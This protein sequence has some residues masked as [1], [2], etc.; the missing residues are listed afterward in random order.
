M[1]DRNGAG[2]KLTACRRD[3]ETRVA[4]ARMRHRPPRPTMTVAV[5]DEAGDGEAEDPVALDGGA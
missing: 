5:V 1:L 2:I 4:P 3:G